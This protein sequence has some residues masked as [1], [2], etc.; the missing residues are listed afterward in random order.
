[1][2]G[3]KDKKERPKKMKEKIT[4]TISFILLLVLCL[5]PIS[6]LNLIVNEPINGKVYDS[7]RSVVFDLESDEDADFYVAKDIY[8][9]EG[10][11]RLCRDKKECEKKVRLA[12]GDNRVLVKAINSKGQSKLVG[13]ISFF[14]D[15]R[16]PRITRT[17]PRRGSVTNGGDFS[18]KYREENLKQITLYYGR[19]LT[20]QSFTKTNCESGKDKTCEFSVDLSAFN[21]K[22]IDY[23]FEIEDVAGSKT[24]SRTTNVIADTSD[25]KINHKEFKVKKRRVSFVFDIEEANFKEVRYMDKEDRRPRWRRLCS[26]LR[27]GRC[28][29]SKSLRSGT[30]ILDIE[31]IDKAGNNVFLYQD[32]LIDI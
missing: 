5:S 10:W 29:P 13:P 24:T 26:N 19:G 17:M 22:E 18:V 8:K 7:D 16:K 20:R 25:P 27:V 4:I 31:A 14:I 3:G 23:W 32:L 21:G 15:T 2:K 28:N 11:T 9:P 12:E 1:M 6:A 30:H